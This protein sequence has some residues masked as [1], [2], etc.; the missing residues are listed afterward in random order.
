[1][2]KINDESELESWFEEQ[3]QHLLEQLE[4]GIAAKKA[5]AE[6][7]YKAEL[8]KVIDEYNIMSS[9]IIDSQVKKSFG[10]SGK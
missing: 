10:R 9:K 8:K 6:D 7:A 3:K 5:D 1:M 4:A 2:K